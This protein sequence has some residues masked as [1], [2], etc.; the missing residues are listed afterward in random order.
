MTRHPLTSLTLWH[1]LQHPNDRT[2]LYVRL[3]LGYNRY[4]GWASRDF[5]L[6]TMLFIALNILIAPL[7]GLIPILTIFVFSPIWAGQIAGD[8]QQ[9]HSQGRFDLLALLPAGAIATCWTLSVLVIRKS[10]TFEYIFQYILD[11]LRVTM[12]L[13][14]MILLI[15]AAI[16]LVAVTAPSSVDSVNGWQLTGLMVALA[17]ALISVYLQQIQAVVLS[18]LIGM[19]IPQLTGNPTQARTWAFAVNLGVLVAIY[20]GVLIPVIALPVGGGWRLLI[21]SV[22]LVLVYEGLIILLWGHL[23]HDFGQPDLSKLSTLEEF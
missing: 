19:S 14:G 4:Y 12:I 17:A 18:Q 10:S 23:Q 3:R 2:P 8:I 20:V 11:G 1:A 7:F 21:V 15:L 9:E 5:N 6:G 13:G 22:V 16:V